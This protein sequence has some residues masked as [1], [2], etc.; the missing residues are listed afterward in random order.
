MCHECITSYNI[1]S[2]VSKSGMRIPCSTVEDTMFYC[3]C[4]TLEEWM[5]VMLK[6]C[7]WS[8]NQSISSRYMCELCVFRGGGG[9]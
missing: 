1:Q 6:A 5:S 9:G 8:K 2:F 3:F 7:T 4:S